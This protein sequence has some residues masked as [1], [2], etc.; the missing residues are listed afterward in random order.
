MCWDHVYDRYISSYI[1]NTNYNR[2]TLNH[3]NH[4]I[5]EP[6]NNGSES[7]GRDARGRSQEATRNRNEAREKQGKAPIQDDEKER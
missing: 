7:P 3:L 6:H 2:Y 5:T 1:L 4:I